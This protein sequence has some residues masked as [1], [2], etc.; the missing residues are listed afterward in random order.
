MK[1]KLK[2]LKEKSAYEI[3]EECAKDGGYRIVLYEI[4]GRIHSFAIIYQG[5]KR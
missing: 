2:K 4:D 1:K 5:V 3:L